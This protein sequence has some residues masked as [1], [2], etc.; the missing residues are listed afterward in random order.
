[1]TRHARSN[2]SS[3]A[4]LY[5]AL[6]LLALAVSLLLMRQLASLLDRPEV[7]VSYLTQECV[8][9]V[10]H[11]AEHEGRTSEWSCSRLPTSYDRVWVE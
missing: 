2:N 5:L 11:A 6:W 3:G 1:M 10:D 7:R 9:V 8:E 4:M